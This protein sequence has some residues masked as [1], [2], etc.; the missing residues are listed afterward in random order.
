[1][2]D[3]NTKKLSEQAGLFYEAMNSLD[4][5]QK[6]EVVA[7]LNTF[8]ELEVRRYMRKKQKID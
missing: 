8:V 5:F 6:Q 7:I 4:C 2:G 1:M 3:E